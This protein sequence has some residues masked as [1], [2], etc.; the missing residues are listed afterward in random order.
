[1]FV[2]I[3]CVYVF[4]CVNLDVEKFLLHFIVYLFVYVY[5][6]ICAS[7]TEPFLSLNVGVEYIIF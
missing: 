7:L 1:M 4:M 5:F 2:C 3:F 6:F